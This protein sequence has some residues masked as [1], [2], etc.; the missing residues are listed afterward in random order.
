MTLYEMNTTKPLYVEILALYELSTTKAPLREL[1]STKCCLRNV[2]YKMW[3]TSF[4]VRLR[5][6]VFVRLR[7]DCQYQW[8]K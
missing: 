7:E 2:F 6:K 3:S 8:K 5:Q 4:N 1:W